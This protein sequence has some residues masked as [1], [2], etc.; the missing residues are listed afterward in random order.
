M[1]TS[2]TF[3]AP[4]SRALL[5]LASRDETK[6]TELKHYTAGSGSLS[7]SSSM[8]HYTP[9]SIIAGTAVTQ[10]IGRAIRV[11]GVEI[12]GWFSPN[13]TSQACRVIVSCRKSGF[14]GT[15]DITPGNTFEAPLSVAE[16]ELKYY[17]DDYVGF[18]AINSADSITHYPTVPYSRFVK[19][20]KNGINVRFNTLNNISDNMP[21]VTLVSDSTALGH[22][23]FQGHIRYHFTD[24]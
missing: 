21:I 13:D 9:N 24:A 12:A 5:A 22:P 6:G 1:P 8:T 10:R 14:T 7:V 11:L 16:Q 2:L 23:V 19:F 18:P 4:T 15:P 20:G 17:L 3:V